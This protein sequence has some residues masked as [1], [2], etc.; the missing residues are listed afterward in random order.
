MS[1]NCIWPIY[2]NQSGA[3]SLGESGP[4]NEG[5]L[6]IPQSSSIS[7]VSPSNCLMSYQGLSFRGSYPSAEMQSVFS[8]QPIGLDYIERLLGM[9]LIRF[10]FIIFGNILFLFR[11]TKGHLCWHFQIDHLCYW[12]W[13][14]I[15]DESNSSIFYKKV[16]NSA[17]CSAC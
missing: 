8:I 16:F 17:G 13:K 10:T 7:G 1:N 11:T 14:S 4:I 15:F 6:Y 3:A 12:H 9:V 5:V 2:R